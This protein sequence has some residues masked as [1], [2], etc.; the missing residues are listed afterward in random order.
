[1]RVYPAIF[2]QCTLYYTH[3][4]GNTK[5]GDGLGICVEVFHLFPYDN[6]VFRQFM[7]YAAAH[8]TPV[9]TTGDQS[10]MELFFTITNGFIFL[11]QLLEHKKNLLD[12]I[13]L[14]TT[15]NN[16]PHLNYLFTH[17]E[18]GLASEHE[19]MSLTAFLITNQDVLKQE[20]LQ[21]SA[22][23]KAQPNLI[24]SL[25]RIIV[26]S[27]TKKRLMMETANDLALEDLDEGKK[28]AASF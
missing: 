15:H 28:R 12:Q 5:S 7:D 25:A 22:I 4:T 27:V 23:I 6:K 2:N 14:I 9:I 10:F 8:H 26:E 18:K 20:S 17:T 16:M 24:D 3:S 13:K 19:L 11:Y 1:M 21:L